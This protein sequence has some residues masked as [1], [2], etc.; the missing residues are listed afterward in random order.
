MGS[1]AD[2]LDTLAAASRPALSRSERREYTRNGIPMPPDPGVP[3]P[4]RLVT[5][6]LFW[7]FV[8]MLMAYSACITLLY[9]QVVPDRKVP[10]GTMVGLG[11]EAI[12]KAARY[13]AYTVI[14]LTALFLWLDRFRP[15]RFFVWLMAFG[16]GACVATYF[17][18][19]INSWAAQHLAIMG[20]GDPATGPRAAI[21]VAPFVEEAMKAS[22]LFWIAILMRY[23]W[24]SRVSGVVLAGLSASAFAFVEN[25]LYYGRIYRAAARTFGANEPMYYLHRLFLQRGVLTCFAHPLFTSMTGI[26]LAIAIRSRSKLVRV[27]APL[28]GY[29]TAAFLHMAFNATVSLVPSGPALIFMY[30]LAL[31]LVLG[32]TIFV[33]RGLLA[34]GRLV[35]HRLEDYVRGGWLPETDPQAFGRLRTRF[36]A[37]WQALWHGP[38]VLLHTFL[39]QRYATELAYLRDGIVRGIT[40]DGGLRREQ[41]LLGRIAELRADAV[42][43]PAARAPYHNL[44]DRLPRRKAKQPDYPPPGFPGPAGLGGNWPAPEGGSWAPPEPTAQQ[45]AA[46]GAAPLGPA[47]TDYSEVDPR[48]GPPGS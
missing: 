12:P 41:Y 28:A 20:N 44:T 19:N 6:P 27:L 29:L 32:V 42:V 11:T 24:V 36:R 5:S 31:A 8:V 9:F 48:W 46:P 33:I 38:V 4:K 7:L 17:A 25:I 43:V 45:G 16:W 21:Y 13:A 37:L 30:V 3:L 10:G 40:D 39:I 22:V 1:L 23:R 35:R 34:Q 15:Q 47:R 2:V 26:G 14:P 18:A